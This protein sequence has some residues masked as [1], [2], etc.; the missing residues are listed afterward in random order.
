MPG[1]DSSASLAQHWKPIA[2]VGVANS[3]LPFV[4]FNTAALAISAG[5]SAIFNATTPLFG[6]LVAWLWLHE[7]LA[8]SR[9]VGLAIG[10]AGVLALAWDKASLRADAG[11]ISSAVA[12]A[13]CLAA[14]LLYGFA[15]TFTNK[16]LSGAGTYAIA[17]GSQLFAALALTPFAA[18]T[19]PATMPSA[20]AW[21]A[22][23]A[24]ALLCSGVAFILYF[25]LIANVGPTNA[26]SVTFLIPVFAVLWGWWLLDEAVSM[27]MLVGCAAIFAGTAL[28]TGMLA[29]PRLAA[30]RS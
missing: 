6:A 9:V 2:L 28:V 12:I 20:L 15:A 25:R 8:V 26:M 23:L 5:L 21:S 17:G 16:R 11:G 29:L 1:A 18:L 19:W 24:L 4:L 3:A 7:R 14:A 27:S 13:A 30:R 10:F 22:A